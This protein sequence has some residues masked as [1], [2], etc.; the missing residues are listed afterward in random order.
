MSDRYKL[1]TLMSLFSV[2]AVVLTGMAPFFVTL[3]GMMVLKLTIPPSLLILSASNS[4]VACKSSSSA[5]V[6]IYAK[7]T[8][9]AVTFDQDNS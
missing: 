8:S 3:K 1:V 4:V 9:T 2:R 7:I 5:S 6:E